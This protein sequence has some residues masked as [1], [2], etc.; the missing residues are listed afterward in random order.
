ME[1]RCTCGAVLPEDAR[2]CHKCG[3]P[4]LPEDIER[5]NATT[6]PDP[7]PPPAP[8]SVAAPSAST[9]ISFRDSRAV[10]ISVIVA[11]GTL[12]SIVIVA[13][14]VPSLVPLIPCAAGFIAVRIYRSQS[15]EP[16]STI[17]GARL[18]WMTGLWLFLVTAIVLATTAVYVASPEGWDQLHSMW[19][20][21]PQLSKLLVSQ[22]DFLMQILLELPIAFLMLTL[23]PG[24]GGILGTK[25][26]SRKRPS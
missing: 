21:V 22:H 2:F 17:A 10:L 19:S 14:L 16:L 23:L 8:A 7:V 4:Q 26:S 18:G 15:A 9:P 1:Q 25:F 3:K 13:L 5:L 20:Q 6:Q 11:A 12:I 24:L